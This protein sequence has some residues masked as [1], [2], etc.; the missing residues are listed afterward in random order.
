MVLSSTTSSIAAGLTQLTGLCLKFQPGETVE[1]VAKSLGHIRGST[2][3]QDL[4]L[5]YPTDLMYPAN[6]MKIISARALASIFSN[7]GH[8]TSLSVGGKIEQPEFDILLTH[9]PHLTSLVCNYLHLSE[10]RSASPCNWEELIVDDFS[11]RTLAYLP[12]GSL[13][14]LMCNMIHEL[15]EQTPELDL[16]VGALV[17]PD[18][19]LE[20]VPH[21]LRRGL[22][23]LLRSP[24]WQQSGPDVAVALSESLVRGFSPDLQSRLL[25]ALAPLPGQQQAGV[26][27]HSDRMDCHRGVSSPAAGQCTGQQPDVSGT[28]VLQAVG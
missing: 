20:Q 5:C 25:G 13:T 14:H 22:T 27:D 1:T 9:A 16:N 15:P 10:D 11:A 26:T 6:A 12:T 2:Q 8:L 3:L 19:V 4:E 21:F 18:G 23:N 24:A 17:G 7:H 28:M